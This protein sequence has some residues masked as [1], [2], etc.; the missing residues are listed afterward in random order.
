[1]CQSSHVLRGLCPMYS[2]TTFLEGGCWVKNVKGVSCP[3]KY[4]VWELSIILAKDPD[5][6][7][8]NDFLIFIINHINCLLPAGNL[9]T[10][11]AA[12]KKFS[13][14]NTTTNAR[15]HFLRNLSIYTAQRVN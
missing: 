6:I 10:K 2:T 5:D 8:E 4:C 1:M 7:T 15:L 3:A 11:I 13:H 14:G 9:L 12:I